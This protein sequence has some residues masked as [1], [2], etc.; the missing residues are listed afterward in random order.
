MSRRLSHYK[1]LKGSDV[2]ETQANILHS[3]RGTRNVGRAKVGVFQPDTST[4]NQY[5]PSSLP[6]KA[7]KALRLAQSLHRNRV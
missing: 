7:E 1:H 2:E 3:H 4:I 5:V 6:M